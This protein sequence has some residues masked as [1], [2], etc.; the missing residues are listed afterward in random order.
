MEPSC[1]YCK[2]V[3]NIDGAKGYRCPYPA[4]AL[5]GEKSTY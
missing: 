2:D 4:S 1:C 5:F 3:F